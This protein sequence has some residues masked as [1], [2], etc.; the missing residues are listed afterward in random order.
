MIGSVILVLP[1]NVP[2]S[3][4]AMSFL[5]M[6]LLGYICYKTCSIYVIYQKST[7]LDLSELI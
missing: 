4:F 2:T 6:I 5:L 7:E 3:G 1:V